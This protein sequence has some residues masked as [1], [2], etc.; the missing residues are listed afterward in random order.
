MRKTLRYLQAWLANPSTRKP[1]VLRGARQVGKTWMV[2]ELARIANK[3][4]IELNFEKYIKWRDLFSSN[5]PKEILLNLESE[6]NI[7]IN[8]EESLLFLDEIQAAPELLAKLRWFYED[9]PS[10]PVIAAGSLLEFTL[11][12]HEFSMPVGRITYLHAEPLSF[13]EFLVAQ[14]QIKLYEFL[15]SWQWSQ[16]IP[17]SLHE[18]L[19]DYVKEYIFVGG[20]PEA[21]YRW[22]AS[23]SLADIEQIHHSLLTTYRDDFAK[24]SKKISTA[25][26][27]EILM[28][29]PKLLGEKFV[30]SRVNKE[31]SA[32]ILKQALQLLNMARVCHKVYATHGNGIPLGAEIKEGFLKVILLDVGLAS[33]LLDT[34]LHQLKQLDAIS[35]V[36][37]GGISEQIVGQLLRTLEPIYKEP[38]LYYWLR[39]HKSANAE[40]DYLIQLHGK[41]VPIKVKSGSTGSLK[42]L[43]QFMHAKQLS[44]AI[45]INADLPSV[46]NVSVKIHSGESVCYELLSIP[47]YLIGQLDRALRKSDHFEE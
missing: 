43:H 39:E 30:F 44:R 46:V 45:R 14:G 15:G 29:I 19:M 9:M 28:T 47:F 33:S 42:S 41:I 17:A 2:R 31:I 40:I 11:A 3:Q 37:Q 34:K 5:N 6:L 13:E 36:N 1:L 7:T 26:L 16:T 8:P 10:L 4:L 24:Y 27:D 22:Q 23:R 38:Q 32:G 12:E 20:M 21:V 18:K 25:R 35:L